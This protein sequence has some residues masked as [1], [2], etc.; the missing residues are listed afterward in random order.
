MKFIF[1]IIATLGLL[2]SN[3]LAEHEVD[4]RYNVRGYIL[5]QDENAISDQAVR[6]FDGGNMLG[7]GKTDSSG[8][9]SVHLH[10]HNDDHGRKFS[11]RSGAS[12]AEFRVSFDPSDLTTLRVHDANFVGNEYIEGPL[13][14]FRIPP[15]VYPLVGFVLI[16]FIVVK[17]EKRRKKK[18]REKAEAHG[19]QHSTAGHKKKKRKRKKG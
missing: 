15:W 19:G 7:E 3:A 14:R 13:S 12:Q 5:D 16:F 17:L 6:V 18:I 2:I 11:L 4:H 9:Y 10:L 8:F 1:L